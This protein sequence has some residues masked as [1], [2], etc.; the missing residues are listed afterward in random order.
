MYATR[1]DKFKLASELGDPGK[2]ST[3]FRLFKRRALYTLTHL[4]TLT[5]THVPLS[6]IIP[7]RSR[8]LGLLRQVPARPRPLSIR[9]RIAKPWSACVTPMRTTFCIYIYIDLDNRSSEPTDRH[10]SLA[11]LRKSDGHNLCPTL[12][13][14]RGPFQKMVQSS[15]MNNWLRCFRHHAFYMM[16]GSCH[17]FGLKQW[18]G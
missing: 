13:T 12:R 4:H 10:L 9:V 1:E 6:L 3:R 7:R 11:C 17:K 2:F 18:R 14:R 5:L 8:D 15:D 16:R